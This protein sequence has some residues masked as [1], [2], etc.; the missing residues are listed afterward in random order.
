MSGT[1]TSYRPLILY[2][3]LLC[4]LLLIAA[5]IFNIPAL[6]IS[7]T[8]NQNRSSADRNRIER[9]VRVPI[10]TGKAS[11]YDLDGKTASGEPMKDEALTAAHPSLPLGTKLHV[12]NL[13]N[14]RSV[15]VR[16]NDRG[17]FVKDRI[18]DLSKAA[19]ERIDMMPDGVAIVELKKLVPAQPD[20]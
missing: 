8:P 20:Q 16:V 15:D 10:E 12:E 1:E 17:P 5:L 4:V 13:S 6:T 14:G 2:A 9:E 19:A 11:W 7:S 18:I 3:A